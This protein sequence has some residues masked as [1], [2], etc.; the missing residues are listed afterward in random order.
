LTPLTAGMEQPW[1][2]RSR[3]GVTS[4]GPL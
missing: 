2:M 3:V 1:R 4:I